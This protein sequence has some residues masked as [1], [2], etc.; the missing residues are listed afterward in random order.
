LHLFGQRPECQ[1]LGLDVIDPFGGGQRPL[2]QLRPARF[3][4]LFGQRS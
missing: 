4:Y 3:L 1:R 2:Q